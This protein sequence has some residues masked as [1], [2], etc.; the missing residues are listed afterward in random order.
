VSRTKTYTPLN[1]FMNDKAV[2]VL[3]KSP[4]GETTFSY[5]TEWLEWD[6]A[7]PVSLSLPLQNKPHNGS[8]VI[9]FF[10]NLLPDSNVMLKGIA[11]RVGAAGTDAYSLLSAIGRDCVGALQFIPEGAEAE[12]DTGGSYETLSRDDVRDILLDLKRAPLGIQSDG[13]FR[14]SLAGAQ[15]KAAFLWKDGQWCR[16]IGTMPTTHIF[17]PQ[18]GKIEM[19]TGTIDLSQSVENEFYCLELLR[20]FGLDVAN[21]QM[22]Q[23]GEKK[24][25]IVERF[26]RLIRKNGSILRLPQEDMCQAL[27]VPPTIKYQNTG[28]PKLVDILNLLSR[29]D[30]PIQDQRSVFMAQ[31][32]FW[33]IGATD[34]HAKNFSLFLR[35]ENRM[36]LTPIYDVI[37]AQPMFDARQIPY[38][39]FRL[40]MSLGKKPRYKI[41][42]IRRRH[43]HQTAIE[44]DLEDAKTDEKDCFTADIIEAIQSR[45]DTAFDDVLTKLPDDFPMA[46]H[47]SIKGA[48]TERLG[49][50]RSQQPS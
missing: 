48:A 39:D 49:T 7:M 17:K 13:G 34:G 45:F 25:L 41:Q 20:A 43:F 22:D 33:L 14:L 46:I 27:A 35:P 5:S 18:I 12:I 24:V 19:S 4:S 32:L 11:E 3:T 44:A 28:G 21:V 42:E 9:S 29:S 30:R 10:D 47:G 36:T 16:P 38:K 2:G 40:A 37:S 26:D 8:A 23:F 31:M 15:E 1:V 6:G 50:L